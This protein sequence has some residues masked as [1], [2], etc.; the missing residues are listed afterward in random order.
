M[1]QHFENNQRCTTHHHAARHAFKRKIQEM[2]R[3]GGS[4]DYPPVNVREEDDKY[5]LYVYAPGL[6][7]ESFQVAVADGVLILKTDP[8]QEPEK[9][10]AYW[11]RQEFQPDGFKRRFELPE[12]TDTEA[13]S[14]RY[15]NGLLLITLP[16]L[17]DFHTK[18][19]SVAVD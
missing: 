18:R 13:I 14:A 5:I 15:E 10:D 6:S 12:G 1:C 2:R 8:Q 4:W 7:K 11:R 9:I 17:E 16:K 3:F 19:R